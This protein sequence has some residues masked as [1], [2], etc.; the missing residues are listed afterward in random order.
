MP[1]SP[2]AMATASLHVP[3]VQLIVE[4]RALMRGAVKDGDSA[5]TWRQV[6]SWLESKLPE[7]VTVDDL[8][9][10]MLSRT[11][12]ETMRTAADVAPGADGLRRPLDP[13]MC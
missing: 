5:A 4:A 6:I 11:A 2:E 13:G 8:E 1:G 7:G 10:P 3:L 12:N 9:D